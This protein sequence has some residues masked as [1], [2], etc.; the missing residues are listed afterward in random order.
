LLLSAA[1]CIS[2]AHGIASLVSSR[3]LVVLF[4]PHFLDVIQDVDEKII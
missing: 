3:P 2:A 4:P 1:Y